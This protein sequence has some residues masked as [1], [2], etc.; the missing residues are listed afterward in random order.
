MDKSSTIM[1]SRLSQS[2]TKIPLGTA[3]LYKP[4]RPRF[5]K[6][7]HL[8]GQPAIIKRYSRFN[9]GDCFIEFPSGGILRVP[10]SDIEPVVT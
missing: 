7:S 9:S 5:F 2:S 10:E 6:D 3:V 8:P 4:K 1:N